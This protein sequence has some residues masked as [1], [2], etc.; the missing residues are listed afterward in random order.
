MKYKC[1]CKEFELSK[2]TI[3]VIDNKVVNPE[4]YCKECKTYAKHLKKFDGW[5]KIISKPGGKA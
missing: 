1:E 3:K 5:G 4:A 2:V